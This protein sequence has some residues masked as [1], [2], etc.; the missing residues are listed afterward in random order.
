MHSNGHSAPGMWAWGLAVGLG[1][2]IG[3]TIRGRVFYLVGRTIDARKQPV[4]FWLAMAGLT[5]PAVGLL[6]LGWHQ[7]TTTPY[8]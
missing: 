6:A 2:Y 5:V 8:R 3:L 7:L 1:L 4:V